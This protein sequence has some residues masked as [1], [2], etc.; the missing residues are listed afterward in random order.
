MFLNQRLVGRASPRARR[1]APPLCRDLS[2]NDM[3]G[4]DAYELVGRANFKGMD[5]L[6]VL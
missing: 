4:I 6:R 3:L 2:F 1:G 5:Y